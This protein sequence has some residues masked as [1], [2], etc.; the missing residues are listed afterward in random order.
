MG[1][2]PAAGT[3]SGDLRDDPTRWLWI[4][5]FGILATTPFLLWFISVILAAS[6]EGFHK[7]PILYGGMLLYI[8]GCVCG[9]C[10]WLIVHRKQIQPFLCDLGYSIATFVGR[11]VRFSINLIFLIL[12]VCT[13]LA[14][15]GWLLSMVALIFGA[16]IIFSL[17]MFIL[18]VILAA[19]FYGAMALDEKLNP[20]K[21][22]QSSGIA[23]LWQ[24]PETWSSTSQTVQHP[25]KRTASGR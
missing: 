24:S 2:L 10:G 14:F 25:D 16:P 7:Q 19:G 20:A 17:L 22:S 8:A 5:I 21:S 15:I 12:A 4:P 13:G 18:L 3:N 1:Q 9:S 23:G 11:V 6:V